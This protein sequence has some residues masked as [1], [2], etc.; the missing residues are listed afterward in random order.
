MELVKLLYHAMQTYVL[1]WVL[2]LKKSFPL[3]AV[4]AIL[5]CMQ[6]SC[7]RAVLDALT[8]ISC[9]INT[10]LFTAPSLLIIQRLLLSHYTVGPIENI[11]AL[12]SP[13]ALFSHESS[14]A[15]KGSR[16]M[17]TPSCLKAT[18]LTKVPLLKRRQAGPEE[19]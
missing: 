1:H 2:S 6:P 13:P 15:N 12:I 9:Q 5:V 4:S 7:Y 3:S 8:P 19:G 10:D 17:I 18:N 11:F 14:I 16:N